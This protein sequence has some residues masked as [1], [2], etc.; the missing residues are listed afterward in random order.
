[1]TRRIEIEQDLVVRAT[2]IDEA[3]R[4]LAALCGEGD[5]WVTVKGSATVEVTRGKQPRAAA[6]QEVMR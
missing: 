4:L 1:M 3:E 5:G 6:P 2:T